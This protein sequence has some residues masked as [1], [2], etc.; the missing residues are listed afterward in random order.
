[1][2][3]DVENYLPNMRIN[4]DKR[5][6][7]SGVRGFLFQDLLAI[8]ELIKTETK[9]ICSEYIEDVCAVTDHGI[10]IIQSKYFPK[11]TLN[12]K[13]VTREL[14]YQF[15]KLRQ[16]G[17]SGEVVP[18][19]GF[20]A[21]ET[22]PFPDLETSKSYLSLTGQQQ[23]FQGTADEKKQKVLECIKTGSKEERENRLFMSFY[24]EVTLKNFLD[25]YKME[26]IK[27]NIGNYRKKLGSELDAL[28]DADCC[29]VDSED[30]RQELLIALAI[31]LVQ[32]RYNEINQPKPKNN[33]D[34]LEHRKVEREDFL[35]KLRQELAS[36]PSFNIIVRSF[37]DEAYCELADEPLSDENR[38]LLN[39]LYSSSNSWLKIHMNSHEDVVRLLNTVSIESRI[40]TATDPP[41]TLRRDLYICKENIKIFY[42][43]VWKI[44]L[45]LQQEKFE[46][47]LL[48]DVG[49][50]IAF[51]FYT[52]NDWSKRSI[53][54]GELGANP[55]RKITYAQKRIRDW[56]DRPQK[57]Y[58][59]NYSIRG[60]GDYSIDVAQFA[61]ETK[62]DV[63][64][65]LPEQFVV[66]CM[67]C[68]GTDLGDWERLEDCAECIFSKNC[69]RGGNL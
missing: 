6:A 16:Y 33:K 27:E 60:V 51:S 57:W 48:S 19:L 58:L 46:E 38:G 55:Y 42:L 35:R 8:A 67:D 69:K 59:K 14:Y 50:Y 37:I 49:N 41:N 18:V 66:E 30:N 26:E 52:H 61:P 25:T 9:F 64:S 28:L 34:L 32:D 44:K 4:E 13:E 56:D 63:K 10:R 20:H 54:M 62:I 45:D 12:I 5:D 65:I 31:K 22:P 15:I 68:I 2:I 36:E 53:I 43:Q 1:M 24:E 7:A 29:P 11:S 3:L 21:K 23:C 40:P 17:Y 39:K 47:C